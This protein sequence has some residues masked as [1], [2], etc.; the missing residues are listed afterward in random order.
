MS[1]VSRLVVCRSASLTSFAALA[2]ITG[3]APVQ[4]QTTDIIGVRA[5]GMAGAFTAVADDAT[6]GYWNPAGLAGGPFVNGSFEYGKPD[7]AVGETMKGITAAYPALGV[8]YYRLPVSQIRLKS[9]TGADASSRKDQSDLSLFGATIGQSIGEHLVIGSTLKL[10]HAGDTSAD[11][12]VGVMATFGPV[13]VGA[14]LR[15]VTAP[16]FRDGPDAFTLQRHARAG[17]ALT[18][19]RRGVIGSAT[20]SVDADLTRETGVN[21][22]E[23]VI[24]AGAEVWASHNSVGVRG[25]FRRN[26][27]GLQETMLAGGAS[28]ALRST[29]FVDVY[30]TKGDN[31]RHGLG[32]ALRVTF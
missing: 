2:F 25:G 24:A 10:L 4:A 17:F 31:V 22:D 14:T 29:T 20:V 26:T 6:A 32:A 28:V 12:D 7:R 5:Q 27:V 9:S 15:N 13:R 8:S 21:G 19:G 30:A 3:A 1:S 16:T 11:L 23:R 18:S